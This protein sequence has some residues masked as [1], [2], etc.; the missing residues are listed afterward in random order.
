MAQK[1][2]EIAAQNDR[3]FADFSRRQRAV[4]DQPEEHRTPDA[5]DDGGFRWRQAL[6]LKGR[7]ISSV[8]ATKHFGPLQSVTV[9]ST[10]KSEQVWP[11]SDKA[12]AV[13]V[14]VAAQF[15]SEPAVFRRA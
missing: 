6:G 14:G 2:H 15:K 13:R 11:L 12:R 5:G 3:L 9:E 1:G 8:D 4:G 7:G 10:A